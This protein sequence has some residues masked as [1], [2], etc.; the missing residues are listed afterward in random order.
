MRGDR[1]AP[2][3]NAGWYAAPATTGRDV[4]P[5]RPSGTGDASPA[6]QGRYAAAATTARDDGLAVKRKKAS[7][8]A[9]AEDT[10]HLSGKFHDVAQPSSPPRE[11]RHQSTKVDPHDYSRQVNT[12]LAPIPIPRDDPSGIA[13]GICARQAICKSF[14]RHDHT[15]SRNPRLSHERPIKS[16]PVNLS[17]ILTSLRL[18][19]F[20]TSRCHNIHRMAT[21][22]AFLQAMITNTQTRAENLHS[23]DGRTS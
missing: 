17:A 3:A 18:H 22:R 6:N 13:S 11:S 1:D 23:D 9:L 5:Q 16:S 12:E 19:E 14:S 2:P 4:D 21:I 10:Q 20:R 7:I 8:E 15:S